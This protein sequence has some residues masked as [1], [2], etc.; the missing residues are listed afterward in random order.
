MDAMLDCQKSFL[1]SLVPED[2]QLLE[3]VDMRH[4]PQKELAERF[5]MPYS[6]LKSRVQRA[7]QKTKQ[8]FLS[9]CAMEFDA[10]GQIQSCESIVPCCTEKSC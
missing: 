5:D 3:A 9:Q 10:A 8:R 6:T 7:R 4:T 1:K 2:Q